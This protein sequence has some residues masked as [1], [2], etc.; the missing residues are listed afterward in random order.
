METQNIKSVSPV[1]LSMKPVMKPIKVNGR[2]NIVTTNPEDISSPLFVGKS[3]LLV[4]THS[5]SQIA[6]GIAGS[7]SFLKCEVVIANV[8][9]LDCVPSA[10]K[11]P[12]R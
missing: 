11:L 2:K 8:Q 4:I 9:L 6:T 5:K 12:L 7:R 3:K 1:L 10:G